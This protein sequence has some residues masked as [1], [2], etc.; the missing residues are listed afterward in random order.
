[1]NWLI[2][3]GNLVSVPGKGVGKVVAVDR[4]KD[5]AL[6]LLWKTEDLQ[7][8]SLSSVTPWKGGGGYPK[9]RERTRRW[10]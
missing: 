9:K 5:E 8:V 4:G 7:L 2:L 10:T 3:P 6:C 1:M